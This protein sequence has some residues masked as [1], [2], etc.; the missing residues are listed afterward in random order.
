MSGGSIQLSPHHEDT[1]L[2][3]PGAPQPS[4]P[5]VSDLA[6]QLR[7]SPTQLSS[8]HLPTHPSSS[9]THQPSSNT[10]L[11]THPD[12]ILTHPAQILTHPTQILTHP[13]QLTYPPTQLSYSTTDPPSSDTHSPGELQLQGHVVLTQRKR[14]RSAFSC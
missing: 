2:C 12:Q 7:Y 6:T 11:P 9:D 13:A 3:R 8:A 4:P 10:H 1:G 5:S 14:K